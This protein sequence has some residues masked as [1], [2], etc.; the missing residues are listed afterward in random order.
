MRR[1]D[2]WLTGCPGTVEDEVVDLETAV[3]AGA[4]V[5]V[6]SLAFAGDPD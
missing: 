1:L 5:V 4:W 6:S 3:R 2:S